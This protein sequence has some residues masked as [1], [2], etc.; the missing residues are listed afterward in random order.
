MSRKQK[1]AGESS[2]A[3]ET[4]LKKRLSTA[5]GQLSTI[6]NKLTR[7]EDRASRWKTE[8]KAQRKLASKAGALAEKLQRKLDRAAAATESAVPEPLPESAVP[9]SAVPESAVPESAVPESAVADP[10]ADATSSARMVAE[11]ATADGAAGPDETWSVVQLRA[12][13]RARGLVGL[14]NKPKAEL[15]AALS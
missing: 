8:A 13:A 1:R 10:P 7:A 4:E 5:Q 14:S 6:E 12:E 9:E 3:K 2:S 15:I 11:P